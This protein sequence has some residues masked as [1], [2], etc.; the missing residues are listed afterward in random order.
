MDLKSEGL[1]SLKPTINKILANTANGIR[2]NT[3][4]MSPTQ[5]KM[6]KP[7]KIADIFVLPPD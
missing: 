7:C 5:V 1:A 4:G 3:K 6:K 2:F